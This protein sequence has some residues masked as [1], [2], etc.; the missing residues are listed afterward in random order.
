M[1]RSTAETKKLYQQ[2]ANAVEADIRS[3]KFAPGQRV[4]S[5]RDLAEQ[6]G[7]SRP[8][9]REAMLALEIRGLIE[10]RH[11]SGIY[12][13]EPGPLAAETADLDIGAF[14]LTEA[15][16]LFEGEAAALAATTI[17]EDELR[18]RAT[19]RGNRPIVVSPSRSQRLPIMPRSSP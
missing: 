8:T 12:V 15:R 14:E 4:P 16:A 19:Q 9:V 1:N 2:V 5:E 6:F 18:M 11:G 13:A 7:V 3:G 17:S 10:A